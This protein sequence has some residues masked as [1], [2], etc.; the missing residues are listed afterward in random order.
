MPHNLVIHNSI[1][2][3]TEK[4]GQGIGEVLGYAIL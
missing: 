1:F 2:S 3:N 4:I